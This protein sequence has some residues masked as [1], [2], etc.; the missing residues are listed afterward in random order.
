[1]I[2]YKFVPK[3]DYINCVC[4]GK[5]LNLSEYNKGG[6]SLDMSS[7]NWEGGGI[8][9]I[10]FGFGSKRDGDVYFLGICDEC[11]DTNFQNGRLRYINNSFGFGKSKR[12]IE[13][14]NKIRERGRN[15]NNLLG[16]TE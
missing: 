11:V 14:S 16:S 2:Q 1:M 3:F 15:L 8:S 13:N 10:S 6:I 4:C 7:A 12:E 9:E 5:E